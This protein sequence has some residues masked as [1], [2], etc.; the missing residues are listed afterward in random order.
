MRS[1]DA[2]AAPPGTGQELAGLDRLELG[3]RLGPRPLRRLFSATWPKVAAITIA[4][5]L[6]QL[7]VLAGF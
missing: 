3:Q 6:W 7:V 2:I 1:R 5:G 4:L